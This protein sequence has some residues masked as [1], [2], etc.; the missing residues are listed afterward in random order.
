MSARDASLWFA[1][2]ALAAAFLS[3][4]ADRFGL[5]G[6]VNPPVV[7]WGSMEGFYPAVAALNPWAPSA[8]IPA[9]AWLVTIVEAVL[10]VLLIV[11]FRLRLTALASGVLLAIFALTMTI[12]LGP[13]LPLNYSVY[14]AAA[15]AFLVA[16]MAEPQGR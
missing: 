11:G 10:G 15:C 2:L 3:A 13:K 8:L 9:L 5:W 1:R 4:V 12:F 14:T 16:V 6:P 7:D